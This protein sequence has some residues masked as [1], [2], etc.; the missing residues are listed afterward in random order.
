MH[1]RNDFFVENLLGV[2]PPDWNH[3]T[4][5]EEGPE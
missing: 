3:A 2:K 1:K 4:T 5:T